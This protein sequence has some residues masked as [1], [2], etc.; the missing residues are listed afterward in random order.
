MQLPA[1]SELLKKPGD[2]D[3]LVVFRQSGK[4]YFYGVYTINE[5]QYYLV[6]PKG[7]EIYK[8]PIKYKTFKTPPKPDH[9]CTTKYYDGTWRDDPECYTEKEAPREQLWPTRWPGT[10][11]I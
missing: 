1:S 7:I 5:Q 3:A 11:S 2:N 4:Y 8:P 9:V 10:T 6:I